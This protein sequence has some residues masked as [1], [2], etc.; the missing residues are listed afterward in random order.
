MFYV[1]ELS[2][3]PG[4]LSCIGWFPPRFLAHQAVN[5]ARK[6]S[7]RA[8]KDVLLEGCIIIWEA[9]VGVEHIEY[10]VP[11]ESIFGWSSFT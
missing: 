8:T 11:R 10:I 1:L 6:K 5:E 9:S 2:G 7:S 4:C 3:T